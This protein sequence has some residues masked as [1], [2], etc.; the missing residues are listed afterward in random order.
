M[1]QKKHENVEKEKKVNKK[2]NKG[3]VSFRCRRRGF[4]LVGV[5]RYDR[6]RKRD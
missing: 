2:A 4:V 3:A 5:H 1:K 6:E